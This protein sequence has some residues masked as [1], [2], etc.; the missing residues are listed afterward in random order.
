M[1]RSIIEAAGDRCG[2]VGSLGFF[3]GA[4]T[5]PA[6]AGFD[7]SISGAGLIAGRARRDHQPG[8]FVPGSPG[9][10]AMLA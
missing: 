4:T 2:L 7:R 5:R 6:G 1:V 8:A 3:D 10:A 9:L